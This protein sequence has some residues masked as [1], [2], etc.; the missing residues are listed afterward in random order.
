MP[1]T[2][3]REW[4]LR[5]GLT[6]AQAA[7]V[8]G[9]SKRSVEMLDRVEVLPTETDYACRWIEDHPE[10]LEVAAGFPAA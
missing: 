8:L 10:C 1:L 4:R 2:P 5:L 6:Q 3:F 7:S 9:R